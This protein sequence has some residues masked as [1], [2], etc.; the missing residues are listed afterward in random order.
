MLGNNAPRVLGFSDMD[1]KMG[2]IKFAFAALV[3]IDNQTFVQSFQSLY[4]QDNAQ[5]E[6]VLISC[7]DGDFP[8]CGGF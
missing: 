3:S 2:C 7:G 8:E 5:A 1:D 6:Q 4:A